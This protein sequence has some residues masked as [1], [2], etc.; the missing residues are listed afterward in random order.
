MFEV[1]IPGYGS[2]KIQ[3]LVLDYNGTLAVDGA[4][5]DGVAAQLN[6]LSALMRIHVITADTFGKAREALAEISC[7]LTILSDIAQDEQKQE[8]VWKLGA[9]RVAA[10]GNGRN[11][12][13]MLD[14]AILGI[15]VLHTECAAAQTLRDADMVAPNIQAALSLFTNPLRLVATL[16]S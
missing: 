16:R 10:I 13:L 14:A 12:R 11:D 8:F 4:L 3:H 6:T 1:D 7:E 5:L 15:G 9:N 2:L